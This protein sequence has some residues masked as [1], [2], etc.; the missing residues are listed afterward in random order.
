[1]LALIVAGEAIFGLPFHVT[2][3]FRGTVLEVFGLTNTEFGAAQAAYGVVAMLMYFPGGPMADRFS[4]R[5]L[6]CVSLLLTTG[7][8]LY[9]AS[10]PGVRGSLIVWGFFGIS[11][12]L[13]F[14]AALIKATRDWGGDDEQGRAF[15]LLDGGRGLLAAVLAVLGVAVFAH[16]FTEGKEATLE[17]NQDALRLVIYGY[18]AVTM[19]AAALVWF[20]VP[21]TTSHGN[22]SDLTND[23]TYL[24]NLNNH[25][26]HKGGSPGDVKRVLQMPLV[27]LQAMIILCA[28]VGFKG[29]DN[30]TLFLQDAYGMEQDEAARILSYAAFLRPVAAVA[31]GLLADKFHSTRVVLVFFALLL[32]PNLY[33][34]LAEPDA[35]AMVIL[36]ANIFVSAGA[37]F[38]LRG[39]YFALFQEATVP[40]SVTGTAVGIVSVIGY[41]P[42]IFVSLLGGILLDRNPG[43]LGHQHFFLMIAGFAALGLLVTL[44]FMKLSQEGSTALPSARVL[45]ELT[46]DE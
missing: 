45:E 19:A 24:P 11:T 43:A 31:A 44:A 35:N 4:V 46:H 22:A 33:L 37:V 39:V 13:F 32:A 30:F 2:R 25:K 15:G 16:I 38:A 23:G 40:P 34:G 36:V 41:T 21:E 27:W 29:F 8:G 9:M 6:L 10:F 5:K 20:F 1:M 42:D 3:F 17:D 26:E 18:A 28:Y 7:G 14:W 12:I